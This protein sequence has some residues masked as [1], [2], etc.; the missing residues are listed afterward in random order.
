LKLKRF[1][2][3]TL[4]CALMG[5]G[6]AIADPVP[7][8]EDACVAGLGQETTL[9]AEGFVI[10]DHTYDISLSCVDGWIGNAYATVAEG[11]TEGELA[12]SRLQLFGTRDVDG[13][14]TVDSACANDIVLF[15][16]EYPELASK[17]EAKCSDSQ[18]NGKNGNK[19]KLEVEIK[20]V[21]EE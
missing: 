9:E 7:V 14:E 2:P 11:E 15:N 20:K 18:G 16:V 8:F 3:A 4:A 10:G 17:G 13:D 5:I 12:D 6:S 19:D 1:I 21:D